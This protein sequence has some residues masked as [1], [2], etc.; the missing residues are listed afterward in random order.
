MAI[1]IPSSKIYQSSN[2][3]VNKKKIEKID[4]NAKQILYESEKQSHFLTKSETPTVTVLPT[5]VVIDA[6]KRFER[7]LDYEVDYKVN[8]IQHGLYDDYF[9]Y[10]VFVLNKAYYQD[11][12]ISFS[13]NEVQNLASI[14]GKI[15]ANISA[16][17]K[18]KYPKATVE[19]KYQ[20]DEVPM[21]G[22]PKIKYDL[23]YCYIEPDTSEGEI[24]QG[25]KIDAKVS[26]THS[27]LQ[28][29]YVTIKNPSIDLVELTLDETGENYIGTAHF[30]C[31][32][33]QGTAEDYF[34]EQFSPAPR[35]LMNR[36]KCTQ[37]I[38]Q[39]IQITIEG[40]YTKYKIEDVV[41]T[42]GEPYSK[43]SLQIQG[44]ELIQANNSWVDANSSDSAI[45]KTYT[46][47]LN[48][49][50]NGKE[51]ATLKCSFGD[52]FDE[53]GNLQLGFDKF[54]KTENIDVFSQYEK[55][56]EVNG[57]F[58][59]KT[60]GENKIVAG[61]RLGKSSTYTLYQTSSPTD[62]PFKLDMVIR[63]TRI[64]S[65]DTNNAAIVDIYWY[66]ENKEIKNVFA[67]AMTSDEEENS[68]TV[69]KCYGIQKIDLRVYENVSRADFE[70]SGVTAT[71]IEQRRSYFEVG[72]IVIPKKY[73]VTSE[74]LKDVPMS[75]RADGTAKQFEVIGV[76]FTF[77]GASWQEIFLEEYN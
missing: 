34:H 12:T 60:S 67:L 47:V 39:D 3:K 68:F 21:P 64:P 70:F 40:D 50:I 4:V 29:L 16:S 5:D 73:A 32:A 44:N 37:Y 56:S 38:P 66:D 9:G 75:L 18:I 72:D 7:Y 8:V 15:Y 62:T 59:E 2:E 65:A 35:I 52:Y 14:D 63:G 10:F 26:K 76:N 1:V 28:D 74:G 49:Y 58:W 46:R 22:T 71:T 54:G 41:V 25:E 61:N 36:F 31:G 48:K 77:D 13:K 11:I 24:S 53:N 30:V 20:P 33:I 51:T 27:K 6:T 57:V 69:D 17:Y 55:T 19:L 23:T 45:S 43:N 42:V